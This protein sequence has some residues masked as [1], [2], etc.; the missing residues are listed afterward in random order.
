MV[1]SINLV[2]ISAPQASAKTWNTK[3]RFYCFCPVSAIK[4]S[5]FIQFLVKNKLSRLIYSLNFCI[6]HF[7]MS[8]NGMLSSVDK[9]CLST[10]D[11]IPTQPQNMCAKH[12]IRYKN[13]DI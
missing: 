6:F 12:Q 8:L 9:I 1:G 5:L 7:P 13:G 2:V 11:N 4:V 10:D 3:K